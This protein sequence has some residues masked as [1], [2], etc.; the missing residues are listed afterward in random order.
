MGEAGGVLDP[1]HGWRSESA[2]ASGYARQTHHME[3]VLVVL[4]DARRRTCQTYWAFQLMEVE[5]GTGREARNLC[6]FRDIVRTP[7]CSTSTRSPSGKS[8]ST[9]TPTGNGTIGRSSRTLRA[10]SPLG[11]VVFLA[12]WTAGS[13]SGDAEAERD[14]E[15]GS[16]RRGDCDA[17]IAEGA[18]RPGLSKPGRP[19][20]V[21]DTERIAGTGRARTA[22]P[23]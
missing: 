23:S 4:V 13:R 20:C 22:G 21:A 14:R 15:A 19:G 8:T 7:P 16:R 10:R 1:G 9:T 6:L 12:D 18:L 5:V 17:M 2:R 11:V 3:G